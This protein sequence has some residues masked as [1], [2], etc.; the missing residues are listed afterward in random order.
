MRNHKQG[1]ASGQSQRL[2]RWLGDHSCS[3]Y[4]LHP[5]ASLAVGAFVSVQQAPGRAF[6]LALML[7]L[8]LAAL[9]HNLVEQPAIALGKRV[10]RS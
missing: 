3:V 8:A 7:T 1:K 4:L 10:T 9:T 6:A 5:L 2:L